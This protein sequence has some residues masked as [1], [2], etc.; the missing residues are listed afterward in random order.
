MAQN[1]T[2]KLKHPSTHGFPDLFPFRGQPGR[3]GVMPSKWVSNAAATPLDSQVISVGI[4][5]TDISNFVQQS[6]NFIAVW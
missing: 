1:R 2:L 3:A 4:P 5:M 6:H